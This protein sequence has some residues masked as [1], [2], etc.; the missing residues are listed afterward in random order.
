MTARAQAL[1]IQAVALFLAAGLTLD[2]GNT[3]NAVAVSCALFWVTFLLLSLSHRFH[4]TRFRRL[5]LRWGLLAFV[6]VGTPL[7]RPVVER[8]ASLLPLLYP[9]L[10]VLIVVPLMYLVTRAF[11]LRSPFDD[12]PPASEA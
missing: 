4:L 2:G 11:G 6:L 1:L 5:F 3:L 8:W 9:G 12:T 7:L 10:A